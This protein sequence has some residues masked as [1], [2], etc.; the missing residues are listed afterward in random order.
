MKKFQKHSCLV[1]LSLLILSG[2]SSAP[3]ETAAPKETPAASETTANN[4]WKWTRSVELVCPFGSGGGTDTSLRALQPYLE[5]ALGTSVIINNQPGSSGLTGAEYF[6]NQPA[7]GYSLLMVT[8]SH[9]I[10]EVTGDMSFKVAEDMEGICILNSEDYVMVAPKNAPYNDL[11]ELQAYAKENPGT[12]T[13]ACISMGGS[14]EFA[15]NTL[16]SELGIEVTLVPYSSGAEQISALLGGFVDLIISAP[17]ESASYLD[18]GDAKA[19]GIL[20]QSRNDILPDVPS[21]ADFG[22]ETDFP[23]F[24][25]MIIKGDA[26]EEAIN[27]LRTAF[28][29][30]VQEEGWKE[31]LSNNGLKS[32]CYQPGDKF[33]PIYSQMVETVKEGMDLSAAQ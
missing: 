12:V 18:S 28:D 3:K 16:C 22:L 11:L 9:C 17:S 6:N 4:E 23:I 24:R 27:A 2:C 10:H 20:S 30:A 25:G 15:L 7:D 19:L 32:D 5:K 13:I 33:M 21:C 29:Q 31:W 14:D 1:L 8:P 26:P